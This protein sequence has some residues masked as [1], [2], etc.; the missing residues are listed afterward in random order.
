MYGAEGG[1]CVT[2]IFDDARAI[3]V[4]INAAKAIAGTHVR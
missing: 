3:L 2:G 1:K 4:W